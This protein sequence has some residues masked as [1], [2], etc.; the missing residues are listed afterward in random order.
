MMILSFNA[1]IQEKH[2]PFPVTQCQKTAPEPS[3]GIDNDCDGK[4]DEETLDGKDN[5]DDGFVDEDFVK[6]NIFSVLNVIKAAVL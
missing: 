5:D 1:Q 4:I 2:W 6:V 3:D